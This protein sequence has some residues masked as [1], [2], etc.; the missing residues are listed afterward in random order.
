M[1]DD[2]RQRWRDALAA[3]ARSKH[4][5]RG[6]RYRQRRTGLAGVCGAGRIRVRVI[7]PDVVDG[8]GASDTA[9]L[10][11]LGQPGS[12]RAHQRGAATLKPHGAVADTATV[13]LLIYQHWS[14]GHA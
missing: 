12:P 11:D 2:Q 7:L 3:A 1:T 5:D 14:L 9:R 4:G 13:G 6:R 8:Q 10:R